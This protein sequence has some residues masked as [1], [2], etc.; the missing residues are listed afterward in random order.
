MGSGRSLNSFL[1]LR[2]LIVRLRLAWL[3]S[4]GLVIAPDVDISLSAKLFPRVPDAISIGDQTSIGPL[5]VLCASDPD[6]S[7]KPIS[8][9]ERCFVGGNVLIGPGVSI[10]DGVVV[11]A[12]A[13]VLRDV[14]EACIVAG[15]PARLVRKGIRTGRFGRLPRSDPSR[16]SHELE[17]V[18]R[19]LLRQTG[20]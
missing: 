1:G 20:R 6:G 7:I 18:V 17:D 8:I 2:K 14:P 12:G 9:G 19:S 4:R 15:N 3:R 5:A 16:Y 11:A 13:V 10:A